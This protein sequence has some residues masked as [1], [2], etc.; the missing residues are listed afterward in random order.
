MNHTLKPQVTVTVTE[1]D[2]KALHA[3][4]R[5]LARQRV[6]LEAREADYLVE[7][8]DT[9]L[10]RR[11]GYSTMAEYM[12]R[13]LHYS[14]HAANER[15]RVAREL[16]KLPLIAEQFRA[17]ELSFSAV[18]ELT[19]VA[20]PATEENWLTTTHGKTARDVERMVAGLRRGDGPKTE[21]DPRL[22]TTRIVLE[23]PVEVAAR[24]RRQRTALDNERGE[25][26]S[27]GEVLDL[28]LRAA[29]GGPIDD[30]TQ[31]AV[32]LA[33]T[34]CKACTQS[35]VSA[36]GAMQPVAPHTAAL[37]TCDAIYIGDLE[38]DDH[39]RPSPTIPAAIRRKVF[40]RDGFACVV[41]G[42]R[43]KRNLDVHHIEFRCHGGK[44]TMEVCCVLCSG[45][46][47]QLHDGRL[48][49]AGKAPDLTFR[50]PPDGDV[51]SATT[52]LS[53]TWDAVEDDVLA[54]DTK[55]RSISAASLTI[56]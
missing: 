43:A 41:P 46:H 21:P 12:E 48:A 15:L 31:P 37:L 40:H 4:L 42:C 53:P 19:R 2:W 44:H 9:H 6:A 16:A 54:G 22:L 17:G 32:Q 36:D 26:V 39:S 47:R 34:T 52:T 10:Y 14:P 28:W 38:S 23:V 20:T 24:Y 35:F 45:H 56:E 30:V 5:E 55:Q 1:A 49:I 13:E 51:E 25:R 8:D 50:F 18:R 11:L 3:M 29:D 33:V 27:D 7:A